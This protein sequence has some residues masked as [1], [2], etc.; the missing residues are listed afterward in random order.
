M[1]II[2]IV[3]VYYRIYIFILKKVTVND[4]MMVCMG[5]PIIPPIFKYFCW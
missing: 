5:G 3:A 4:F 1:Y 2:Y